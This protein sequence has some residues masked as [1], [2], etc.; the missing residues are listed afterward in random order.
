L[1]D[2]HVCLLAFGHFTVSLHAQRSIFTHGPKQLPSTLA[3]SPSA[4]CG[5]I[6]RQRTL[7]VSQS[8]SGPTSPPGTSTSLG[9]PASAAGTS[10]GVPASAVATGVAGSPDV[11]GVAVGASCAPPLLPLEQPDAI[12]SASTSAMDIPSKTLRMLIAASYHHLPPHGPY[13]SRGDFPA[14]SDLGKAKVIHPTARCSRAA[15][16]RGDE[17]EPH[18][19]SLVDDEGIRL[20]MQRGVY[21]GMDIYNS[22]YTQAEGKKNG[23]L[24]GNRQKDREI[25]L[26]QR[27]NYKKASRPE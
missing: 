26:I 12:A 2:Q 24:E 22:D 9:V 19:A 1:F 11:G 16:T 14:P 8:E 6:R 23:V 27:R 3:A 21:F 13:L 17:E 5:G 20:A 7:P 15:A 18:L 10:L 25:A 4:H